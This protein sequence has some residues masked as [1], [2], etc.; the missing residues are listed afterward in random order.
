MNNDTMNSIAVRAL[1]DLIDDSRKE[2][3]P[4]NDDDFADLAE[5]ILIN[6]KIN[7][8][9]DDLGPICDIMIRIC[10]NFGIAH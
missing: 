9:H 10:D 6:E 3:T 8:T 5:I 4:I 1:E 2:G 7:F